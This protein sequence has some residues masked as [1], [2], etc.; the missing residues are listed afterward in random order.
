[1]TN[2]KN[3]NNCAHLSYET[4]DVNDD[5][6][7]VCNR[8]DFKQGREENEM[9]RKMESSGYRAWPKKCFVAKN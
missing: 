1:M 9:L 2:K 3:C 8:K 7:F 4:G 6:G 5:E